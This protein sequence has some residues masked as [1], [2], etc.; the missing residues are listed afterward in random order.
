M[1]SNGGTQSASTEFSLIDNAT[2]TSLSQRKP[3]P[4]ASFSDRLIYATM[5]DNAG[6]TQEANIYWKELAKERPQDEALQQ[7]GAR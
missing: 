2:R 1:D 3:R 6:A 4:N 5:L 7:L